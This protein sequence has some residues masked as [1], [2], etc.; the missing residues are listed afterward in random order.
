M[1]DD[2]IDYLIRQTHPK[3]EFSASFQ[4][5]VW[6]QIAVVEQHSWPAQCKQWSQM[7]FLWLARPMPAVA[8]VAVMLTAGISL[9]NLTTPDQSESMRAAYIES[10]NPLKATHAS[11]QP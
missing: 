10:I 8:T 9:G 5:E 4:R 7:F 1:N 6:G 3:P 11:M 2:E